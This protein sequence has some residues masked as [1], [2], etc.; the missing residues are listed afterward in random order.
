MGSGESE[1]EF[2]WHADWTEATGSTPPELQLTPTTSLP[3]GWRIEQVAFE[4]IAEPHSRLRHWSA[5]DLQRGTPGEGTLT[6][7][8]S[9]EDVSASESVVKVKF[10]HA[11]GAVAWEWGD[12]PATGNQ[13]PAAVAELDQLGSAGANRAAKIR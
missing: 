1:P 5:N 4:S 12:V 11:N 10:R 13:R 9:G 7:P 6:I 2:E 8:I 3:T